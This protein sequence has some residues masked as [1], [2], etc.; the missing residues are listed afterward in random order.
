MR[1]VD[2]NTD[3]NYSKNHQVVLLKNGQ[4]ERGNGQ[5]AMEIRHQEFRIKPNPF[6][7]PRAQCPMPNAR[8]PMTNTQS[9]IPIT[10]F[11]RDRGGKV[12]K[13]SHLVD[14]VVSQFTAAK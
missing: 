7:I 9:S 3:D 13:F 12:M 5:W 8:C 1:F 2:V 6:L 14:S 4:W 10:P 11:S